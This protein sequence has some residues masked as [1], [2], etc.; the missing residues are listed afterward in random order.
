M[1]ALHHQEINPCAP[2]WMQVLQNSYEYHGLNDL[3][4]SCIVALAVTLVL[5]WHWGRT[6]A[7]FK[8]TVQSSFQVAT[9]SATS[10]SYCQQQHAAQ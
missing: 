1:A 3:L 7:I 5:Y 8:A 2:L 10:S 9:P 4:M 6:T